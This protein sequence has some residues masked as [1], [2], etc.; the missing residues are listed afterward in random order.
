MNAKFE[1]IAFGE[2]NSGAREERNILTATIFLAIRELES[3]SPIIRREARAWIL[4]KTPVV[5]P[6]MTFEQMCEAC[7][8]SD[9]T[10]KRLQTFARYPASRVA[11]S[12]LLEV[13]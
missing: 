12:R 1:N 9:R 8:I 3:S 2:E 4:G 5:E 7:D 11:S 10:V 6:D 13:A